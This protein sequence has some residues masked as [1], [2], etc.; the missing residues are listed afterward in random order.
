MWCRTTLLPIANRRVLACLLVVT[1]VVGSA[2]PSVGQDVGHIGQNA[3]GQPNEQQPLADDPERLMTFVEKTA[4][5]TDL[6]TQQKHAEALAAFEELAKN[7]ADLDEDHYVSL[8]LADCLYA[9]GRHDQARAAYKAIADDPSAITSNPKL[10]QVVKNRLRD[11]E[12]AG[13]RVSDALV[14]ELRQEIS[15]ATGD[16]LLA[17][18]M[19]LG[20]ALQK[21]AAEL[22]KEAVGLFRTVG[23]KDQRLANPGQRAI[24]SQ[25]A[26]LAEIQEDLASLVDRAEKT[27]SMVRTWRE[28]TDRSSANSGMAE[29]RA[30]WAVQ[31]A[32][33]AQ[34]T[35]AQSPHVQPANAQTV[36]VQVAWNNGQSQPEVLV[37]GKAVKLNSTQAL[38]LQRHAE[39]MNAV[40]QEAMQA[41]GT[42]VGK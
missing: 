5:A 18:Q 16:Q 37:N 1:Y 7:Y 11:M 34:S 40:V 12:L 26:V 39:R 31:M 25:L 21:R 38:I 9:M 15:S 30:A 3:S 35:N 24:S 17:A 22:L 10:K 2:Q 42:Q 32:A 29:Y 28:I 13:L 6:F 19:Q 36:S 33:D 14:A 20:R 41:D 8:S 27:W 4:H 23:E